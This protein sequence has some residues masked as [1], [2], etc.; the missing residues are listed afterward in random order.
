[1]NIILIVKN[2]IKNKKIDM[3]VLFLLVTIAVMLFYAGIS[4]LF[5]MGTGE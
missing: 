2:N 1:M 3:T 4:V 5:N